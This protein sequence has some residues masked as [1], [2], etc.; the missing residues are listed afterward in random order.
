MVSIDKMLVKTNT[1][2]QL[3]PFNNPVDKVSDYIISLAKNL[4]LK[5][6]GGIGQVCVIV[7]GLSI[8]WFMIN[9]NSKVAKEGFSGSIIV[10]IGTKLIEILVK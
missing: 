4:V 6:C 8:M 2:A 5:S 9:N 7:C 1:L 10:Y 3:L